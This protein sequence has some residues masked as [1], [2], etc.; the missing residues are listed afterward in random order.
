MSLLTSADWADKIFTGDWE[1]P[2]GGRSIDV[3]EAATGDKLGSVGMAEAA[4]VAAAADRA[5]RAQRDWAAMPFPERAGV[6]MRAGA[7]MREHAEEIIEWTMRESGSTRPKAALEVDVSFAE[8]MEAAALP[9]APNGELLPSLQP[10]LSMTQQVPVGVVSVISPFNF[11]QILSMRS[12]APALALGNAV[13]LKPDPRTSVCGGVVIA[14]IFEEAGLPAGLLQVLPGDAETGAEMIRNPKVRI[15][16]FTG[17]TAAGR[18]VGALAAEHLTRAHLEL[19]GNSAMIVRHDAD[20]EAAASCGAWGNFLHQGQICMAVGRHL[21]HESLYEQYVELL[22][23]KAEHLPVGDPMGPDGA[24][25]ALGPIIDDR[26]LSNVVDLVER[27]VA[28]GA[29]VV[30][31]ATHTGRFYTP[32]VL[33]DCGPGIPVW[34]EEIFGPVAAVR[35]FSTDDEAVD[36]AAASGYGLSL[37]I[38]TADTARGMELADRIPTGM[39]HINDQTVNDEPNAPFGGVAASGYGRVGGPRANIDAFTE[40]RWLTLR[41]QTAQYPF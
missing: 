30:T 23:K 7:A 28:A 32:T 41:G 31:G 20:V 9:G 5:A 34:D 39:V 22:A 24:H 21:V 12:I 38:L 14:R 4:D 13:L 27:S 18:K 6:L 11:P 10:R 25:V 37:G 19:G 36:L 3:V 2:E 15:V 16:S 35:S 17:S 33:A 26:Q 1:A 29:R 8:C 40:T